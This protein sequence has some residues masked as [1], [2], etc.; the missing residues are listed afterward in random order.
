MYVL[1][2]SKGGNACRVQ[3]LARRR[4][5]IAALRAPWAI[6]LSNASA[7]AA[8]ANKFFTHDFDLF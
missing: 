3:A 4:I 7:Y 1:T 2:K 5:R 6:Q 8:W